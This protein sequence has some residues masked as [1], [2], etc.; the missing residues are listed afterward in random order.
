MSDTITKTFSILPTPAATLEAEDGCWK[1]PLN[2]F[3]QQVDSVTTIT[4]WNWKF[5]DGSVSQE[6]YPHSHLFLREAI[7]SF[8]LL[9]MPIDGC[10]SNNITK[11]IHVEDIYVDAGKDTSVQANVPFKLNANWTGDFNGVPV[12]TWSPANGLSTTDGHDPTAILQNDQ[13]YYLTATTD[14]GC[15]ALDSIKIRVFNSP[16]VL[17][18]SAFTPNSD[19]LMI[20]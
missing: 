20:C 8:I 16:G 11:Q 14:I 6:Q 2:F 9:S 15:K 19:G 12:L 5:G 13:L 4:Q 10:V 1:Q 17:V 3:G 18:P 7:K